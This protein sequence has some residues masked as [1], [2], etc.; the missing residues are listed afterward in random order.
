MS[1]SHISPHI[2]V[3]ELPDGVRYVIRT[4]NNASP[5]L[6]IF[7]ALVVRTP[8]I[9]VVLAVAFLMYVFP[10]I[11]IVQLA[12][13]FLFVVQMLFV[14]RIPLKLFRR[15]LWQTLVSVFGHGEIELRGDRLFLGSRAGFLRSR[16]RRSVREFQRIV[17]FVYLSPPTTQTVQEPAPDEAVNPATGERAVLAIETDD[18]APWLLIDGFPRAETWALAEDLHKHL[19]ADVSIPLPSV[20]ETT[21]RA[22]YPPVEPD[23]ISR[24][25]PF[26]FL[27]HVLGVIGLGAITSI[28]FKTGAWRSHTVRSAILVT[29]LSEFLIFAGTFAVKSR[30][31]PAESPD[32]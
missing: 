5:G 3:V 20:V 13:A 8:V 16:S 4:Q 19:S 1:G 26:W 32:G 15:E 11:S 30:E 28:A 29:W 21:E 23:I 7:L 17:V 18:K 9:A 10:K 2:D 6:A 12:V 24:R 22:L 14:A 25:K 27:M 31:N